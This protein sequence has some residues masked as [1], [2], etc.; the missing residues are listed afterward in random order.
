MVWLLLL[1]R[2][3]EYISKWAAESHSLFRPNSQ[4]YNCIED[5]MTAAIK[6][7]KSK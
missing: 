6:R 1:E 4:Q 2:G 5:T 3:G 7:K